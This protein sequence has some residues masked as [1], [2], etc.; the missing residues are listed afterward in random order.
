MNQLLS[1]FIKF[2]YSACEFKLSALGRIEEKIEMQSYHP[3][4]IYAI[5][6]LCNDKERYFS[7]AMHCKLLRTKVN[8]K[9]HGQ[10]FG[11]HVL[12][13]FH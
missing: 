2:T 5:S 1:I 13:N 3:S 12:I 7:G 4:I 10:L 11:V 6:N 8:M 9:N